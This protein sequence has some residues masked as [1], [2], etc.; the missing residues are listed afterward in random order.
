M[1]NIDV[2][3]RTL[4]DKPLGELVSD[5]TREIGTLVRKEVE[6]ATAE[7]REDVKAAGLGAGAFGAA[8]FTGYMAVLFLSL[9]LM[10]GLAAAGLPTGW[11]AFGVGLLY[12][13]AAG[14]LAVTGRERLERATGL[15]ETKRTIEEDVEWARRRKS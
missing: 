6:L 13:L 15:P 14:L 11:A 2:S 10:F 5:A 9:A 1:T 3:D 4:R 8:A 7:L 12:A